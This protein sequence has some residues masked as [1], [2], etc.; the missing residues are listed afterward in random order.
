MAKE[1]LVTERASEEER[2]WLSVVLPGELKVWLRVRAA[3]ASKSA[4]AYV[5]ELVEKDRLR[6]QADESVA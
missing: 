4:S 2:A 5:R 1:D 6:S 3:T